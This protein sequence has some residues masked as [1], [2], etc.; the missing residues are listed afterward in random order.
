MKVACAWGVW[1]IDENGQIFYYCSMEKE[2]YKKLVKYWQETADY[3]YET[4]KSLYKSK[5]Y[6]NC[7]FFG[8]IVLEKILKALITKNTKKQ[9]PYIHNLARL[10]DLSGIQLEEK[11]IDL[12][13]RVNKFNIRARYPERKLQFYKTCTKEYTT[14]YI[15]DI[16]KLYKKLCQKLKQKR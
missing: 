8:H 3:D 9:P 5:R 11:E 7:L 15:K 6:A 12:L 13:N 4:M 1:I 14:R 16:D 2:G 10:W